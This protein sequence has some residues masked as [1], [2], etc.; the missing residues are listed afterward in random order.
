MRI[1]VVSED[2]PQPHMGGLAKHALALCR[3]LVQMGHQVDILGNDLHAVDTN[4]AELDFGGQIFPELNGHFVQWKEPS[5]GM[6]LP[7]RRTWVA[8]RFAHVIMRHASKYDV[9]HYHGHFPNVAKFIPSDVNFVQT[10]HDQGSDCLFDTRFRKGEVCT[11]TNP[12]ACA[13]CRS[14]QPNGVQRWFSTTSVKRFRSEVMEGFRRHKT[15]FVSDMLH[16]NFS[17]SCGEGPWGVTIHNFVDLEPI[18]QARSRAAKETPSSGVVR[19]AV[20]AKLWAAKGVTPFVHE[21]SR[22]RAPGMELTVV[23]AGPEL[24]ALRS[25]FESEHIRFAGWCNAERTLEIASLAHAIVVP[26]IWEEPCATTVLEGLMLGKTTFALASG[27]TP[28]LAIYAHS[29]E[30]L[31]L[32]ATMESLVDDLVSADL[33][34]TY[35]LPPDGMGSVERAANRLLNLYLATSSQTQTMKIAAA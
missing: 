9:I 28:E 5:L 14:A 19:V 17:R 3:M 27:G 4:N 13:S 7:Q 8:R 24:S 30:Q 11:E 15:V 18:M 32:H 34:K 20:A 35:P 12:E 25:E 23:G 1:L 31:R 10:R 21:F 16:R 6:F 22:K 33:S 26:S 29:P 2:I